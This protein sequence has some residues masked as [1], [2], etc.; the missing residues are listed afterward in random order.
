[1]ARSG[2]NARKQR[3]I[4]RVE[5]LEP[6]LQHP[7]FRERRVLDDR[8]VEI[9]DRIRAKEVEPNRER[10]D[11]RRELLRRDLVEARI[12]VEPALDRLLIARKR[13]VLEV[14]GEQEVP[15]IT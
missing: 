1:V 7:S 12:G 13:D 5:R 15:E 3:V 14:S 9:A 6:E 8:Q 4:E 2:A 11:V 10:A